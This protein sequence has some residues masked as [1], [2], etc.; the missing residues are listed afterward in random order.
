MNLELGLLLLGVRASF[1]VGERGVCVGVSSLCLIC[2]GGVCNGEKSKNKPLLVH[3]K[4]WHSGGLLLYLLFVSMM[5]ACRFNLYPRSSSPS[6]FLF[7]PHNLSLF[8]SLVIAGSCHEYGTDG[9][10]GWKSFLFSRL[11]VLFFI[12]LCLFFP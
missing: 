5:P 7:L 12:F 1:R 2:F 4:A 3:A 9:M 11:C 10:V 6:F 8:L